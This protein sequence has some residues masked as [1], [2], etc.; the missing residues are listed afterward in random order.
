MPSRLIRSAVLRRR[1]PHNPRGTGP[2]CRLRCA[3]FNSSDSG[4]TELHQ[5]A[6]GSPW[7]DISGSRCASLMPFV[8]SHVYASTS[9][10]WWSLRL[11][12]LK[13]TAQ[14]RNYEEVTPQIT[15]SHRHSIK[16]SRQLCRTTRELSYLVVRRAHAATSSQDVPSLEPSFRCSNA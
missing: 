12:D 13:P 15:L 11:V 4:T 5:I 14:C 1:Y 8:R 2:L 3:L 7:Q 9:K 6:G 10:Q 16:H